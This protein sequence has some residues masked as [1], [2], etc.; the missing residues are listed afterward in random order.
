MMDG[1][2]LTPV[3]GVEKPTP[4]EM[5]YHP[6]ANL[7][8]LVMGDE[9]DELVAD[10]KAN[11]LR[12]PILIDAKGRIIDGRNRYR[13]CRVGGVEPRF[14]KVRGKID[15]V[16]LVVSLNV[17][18]RNLDAGQKA[19]AAAEAWIEAEAEG[20]TV[21]K[22]E[23][24]KLGKVPNLIADP[25]GHFATMF[26]TND[27]YIRLARDLIEGDPTAAASVKEGRKSNDGKVIKL[28]AAHEAMVKKFDGQTQI[29]RRIA[30]LRAGRWPE[31]ATAVE[32][33]RLT[34]LAAETEQ[35]ERQKTV[36]DVI[37]RGTEAGAAIIGLR[38]GHS[39]ILG[40]IQYVELSSL[41]TV[42]Q[43][44][45][46]QEVLADILERAQTVEAAKNATEEAT[47]GAEPERA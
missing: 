27:K 16:A 7:F 8:P 15:I 9:F 21:G 13:A 32:E 20:R 23:S 42:A 34:L 35:Q 3:E 45:E 41:I 47:D 19:I 36:N 43:I 10:I 4:P 39:S 29:E 18:R 11:G 1:D 38:S 5:E 33:E 28:P 17:K 30:Y 22:G 26:G 40:A 2:L 25:R 46:A 14:E 44:I 6:A 12:V 37:R 24:G 31:L